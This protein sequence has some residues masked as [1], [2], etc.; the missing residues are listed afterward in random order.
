[1]EIDSDEVD[2]NNAFELEDASTTI[3]EA[4]THVATASLDLVSCEKFLD[5]PAHKV[6]LEST[7]IKS[8]RVEQMFVLGKMDA[9]RFMKNP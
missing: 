9:H 7:G 5:L 2:G 4:P 1:M 6:S 3:K 8:V